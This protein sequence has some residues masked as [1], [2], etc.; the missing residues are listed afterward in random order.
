[1]FAGRI[2]GMNILRAVARVLR[3]QTAA[4]ISQYFINPARFKMGPCPGIT[5]VL[6]PAIA[7][8]FFA[9]ATIISIV[10]RC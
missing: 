10:P 7:I 9:I 2:L 6:G 1:M 3:L 4:N 8:T 5:L